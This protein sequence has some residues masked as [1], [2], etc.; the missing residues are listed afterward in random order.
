MM[1]ATGVKGSRWRR[2]AAGLLLLAALV[3]MQLATAWRL[4][5]T[6]KTR[7]AG[8]L[9]PGTPQVE[10]LLKEAIAFDPTYGWGHW[11]LS[12]EYLHQ[13]GVA[14]DRGA[15]ARAQAAR[16]KQANALRQAQALELLAEGE[17]RKR[18][19]RL[20]EADALAL[21]GSRSFN[22]IGC[23]QQMA[24]IYLRQRRA[25]EAER[26]LWR[27]ARIMPNEI[28]SFERLVVLKHD[29]GRKDEVLALCDQILRRHPYSANAYYYKALL[30]IEE[31]N[32]GEALLNARQ[33]YFMMLQEKDPGRIFFERRKLEQFVKSLKL[34]EQPA[35]APAASR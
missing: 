22:S 18:D 8:V 32:L 12:K 19:E 6:Y 10:P 21:E 26:M 29:Q 17:F 9:P 13:A 31:K 34:A 15:A 14:G 3:A 33:A 23:Y 30:A 28:E 27:V 20:K 7:V 16:A 11:L 24:S 25:E 4:A 5:A 2:L 35:V 1:E